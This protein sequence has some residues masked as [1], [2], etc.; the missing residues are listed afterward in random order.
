M[1]HLLAVYLV[2]RRGEEVL[3]GLRRG[4][5]YRD[6][7]WGLPAGRLEEGER[8]IDAVVREAEEELGL[9]LDPASLH[10]LTAIERDTDTG[11]WLDVFYGC[12]RW[13]GEPVNAEPHRCA[14]LAW[15]RPDAPGITDYVAEVLA[16]L[17]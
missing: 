7:E 14:D 8:L 5:G 15:L 9:R 11:L 16:S 1:A 2:L 3:F 12:D 17:R 4:T 6:G 10:I 13:D